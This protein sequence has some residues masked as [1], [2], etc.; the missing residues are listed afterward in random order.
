M[1]ADGGIFFR[2]LGIMT[3]RGTAEV[4]KFGDGSGG[5]KVTGVLY[6]FYLVK[7]CGINFHH[8]SAR[9]RRDAMRCLCFALQVGG[10][11]LERM[12]DFMRLEVDVYG[13]EQ[14]CV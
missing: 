14:G 12:L 6:R 4:L 10:R 7:L 5:G 3:G 1:T 9:R 8:S 2:G 13:D 11:T